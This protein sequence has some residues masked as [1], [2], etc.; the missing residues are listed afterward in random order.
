MLIV[1]DFLRDKKSTPKWLP[2]YNFT[3]HLFASKELHKLLSTEGP[4][5]RETRVVYVANWP[6]LKAS[7]K[8]S[9]LKFQ[10]K[11]AT[12]LNAVYITPF[13]LSTGRYHIC[14]K[15]TLI[16]FI[17]KCTYAA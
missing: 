11:H 1:S 5:T 7:S 2:N 17:N 12:P 9:S 6:E 13:I 10:K 14:V 15:K 3:A 16:S 4:N 8:R